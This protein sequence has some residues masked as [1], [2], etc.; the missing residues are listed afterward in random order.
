[1]LNDMDKYI[2]LYINSTAN[3]SL[4]PLSA[5]HMCSNNIYVLY[6]LTLWALYIF[7]C[8]IIPP[9]YYFY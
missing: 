6:T 2:E 5:E 9:S 3:I 1:M 7:T 8:T 4:S